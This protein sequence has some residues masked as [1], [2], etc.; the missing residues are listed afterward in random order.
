MS[1][2]WLTSVV[3]QLR[4]ALYENE[5][6]HD[7]LH[8]EYDEALQRLADLQQYNENMEQNETRSFG[9]QA[10]LQTCRQTIETM[11]AESLMAQSA[12]H[13][14]QLS[15]TAVE[16][17]L[18]A[19]VDEYTTLLSNH[20]AELS[21]ARQQVFERDSIALMQA[22]KLRLETEKV[23]KLEGE[24]KTT[25]LIL[26]SQDGDV[27]MLKDKIG[28]MRFEAHE[29]MFQAGGEIS[30]LKKEIE[31]KEDEIDELSE[32]LRASKDELERSDH[33]RVEVSSF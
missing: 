30:G 6:W 1:E 8:F 17:Q 33:D 16:A 24:L 11:T 9:L 27:A 29:K 22:E 18:E 7:K 2:C 4:E 20:H 15:L 31:V 5:Q 23:G 10:E 12:I 19:T 26:A 32:E 3:T 13:D 14:L 21:A 28:Q 25:N